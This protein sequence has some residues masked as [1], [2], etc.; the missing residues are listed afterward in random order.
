M[1]EPILQ[2]QQLKTHF[3]LMEG[4]VPAVEEVSFDLHRGETLGLV[5]E[6]GSGKSVTALSILRLVPDPPGKIVGGKILFE[7]KDLLALPEKEMR[8]IRGNRISMIFQEPMTSLN[9]VLTIGEQ[10]AEGIVLH[11]NVGKKEAMNQ[12]IEMLRKVEIPAPERRVREYPHQLSGGMR[13]RV[14]IAMALAMRPDLL[15][16]DEP[17]TALD[18]TI[19]RQILDLIGKLQEEIGMA[20]LLITH[21]LGII[22]ETAQ[23][24]VVM[25]EG[26]VVETSDVFSLFEKPQH[27]YTRQLLAAVPRLGETKKWS[28]KRKEA[29]SRQPSAVSEEPIF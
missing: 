12:S 24:V 15:I 20:V 29:F 7:G 1:P 10:I 21:N 14:M 4:V 11:E 13:Q 6:S 2:V 17:T 28:K 22:A 5:G 19:Q 3:Y 23:R 9:P 18:V 27:S 16:A 25:K 26:R 8:K